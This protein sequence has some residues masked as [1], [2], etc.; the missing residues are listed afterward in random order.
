MRVVNGS[1][2]SAEACDITLAC[3]LKCNLVHLFQCWV[4]WTCVIWDFGFG[5]FIRSPINASIV[6]MRFNKMVLKS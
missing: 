3:L 4:Y 6:R 5:Y 1:E 2:K